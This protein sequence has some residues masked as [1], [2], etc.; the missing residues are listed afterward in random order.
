MKI[1]RR[2]GEGLFALFIVI[3][4]MFIGIVLWKYTNEEKNDHDRLE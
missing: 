3:P 1:L 2:I 4:V